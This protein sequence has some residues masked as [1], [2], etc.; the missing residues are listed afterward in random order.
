M[1]VCSFCDCSHVDAAVCDCPPTAGSSSHL[2]ANH[3]RPPLR[4]SRSPG[5]ARPTSS[6]ASPFSSTS[7]G[8]NVSAS[9]TPSGGPVTS[10]SSHVELASGG[11]AR[12]APHTLG[13]VSSAEREIETGGG[14]LRGARGRRAG[15][16]RVVGPCAGEPRAL[17]SVAW[18]RRSVGASSRHS[19]RLARARAD[20]LV[21]LTISFRGGRLFPYALDV[22]E[23]RR[24]WAPP[25][26]AGVGCIPSRASSRRCPDG[27][28]LG[29]PPVT[30]PRQPSRSGTNATSSS[31]HQQGTFRRCVI[32]SSSDSLYHD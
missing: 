15:D 26:A 19:A 17:R 3:H 28:A 11:C 18:A 24:R 6:R 16:A 9:T 4:C 21:I 10:T 7:P 32:D 5:L 31:H 30:A 14:R 1:Y 23:R 2:P 29:H 27:R 13:A 20:T 25:I 8:R 22:A 12:V